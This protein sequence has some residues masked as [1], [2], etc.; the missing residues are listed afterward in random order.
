[1]LIDEGKKN[2]ANILITEFIENILFCTWEHILKL[3]KYSAY[4]SYF[5]IKY[6]ITSCKKNHVYSFPE[7]NFFFFLLTLTTKYFVRPKKYNILDLS[8]IS[9]RSFKYS[10]VFSAIFRGLRLR[11]YYI[12]DLTNPIG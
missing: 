7:F 9:R 8:F 3:E 4:F 1:M 11:Y 5:R 10:V 6:N 2:V 12:K